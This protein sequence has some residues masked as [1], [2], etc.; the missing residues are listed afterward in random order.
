MNRGLH[1]NVI[2]GKKSFHVALEAIMD[3]EIPK[4]IKLVPADPQAR[5]IGISK[6]VEEA[7][8]DYM[9][10]INLNAL[11][12]HEWQQRH[13][14]GLICHVNEGCKMSRK[15]WT[16]TNII[17]YIED[18][19][20][21]PQLIERMK[22]EF[23]SEGECIVEFVK[24]YKHLVLE[25]TI[26][27]KIHQTTAIYLRYSQQLLL[28]KKR[29]IR[30]LGIGKKTVSAILRL[31]GIHYREYGDDEHRVFFLDTDVNIYFCKHYQLP[32]Y[33]LQRIE[34]SNKEY[35]SFIL[36]VLPVKKGEW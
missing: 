11:I 16:F 27:P 22:W 2:E 35:R 30:R 31:C 5:K 8:R 32:I 34:F 26:D 24:L 13:L 3:G 1:V 19:K 28:K 7:I 17:R 33:I 12:L 18:Y 23:I 6:K 36:K 29:A 15:H 4:G 25:R 14:Q 9:E 21:N 20:K 10:K